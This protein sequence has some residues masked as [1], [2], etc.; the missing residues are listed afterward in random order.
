MNGQIGVQSIY[1]RGSTFWIK[2][3][4]P[5]AEAPQS[6]KTIVPYLHNLKALIVDDIKANCDIAEEHLL[7][8]GMRPQYTLSPAAV[9]NMLRDAKAT[10]DPFKLVILDYSMPN[11]NGYELAKAI[12]GNDQFADVSLIMLTSIGQLGDGKMFR[13]I[14]VNGYLVKPVRSS[15]LLETITSSL[16]H[17]AQ[18]DAEMVTRHVLN[19]EANSIE[20]KP[21]TQS[22]PKTSEDIQR[23]FSRARL[24]TDFDDGVVIKKTLS[25]DSADERKSSGNDT[26]E[27][28]MSQTDSQKLPLKIAIPDVDPPVSDDPGASSVTSA[29]IL[30][31]EDK[32]RKSVV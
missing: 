7:K 26:P 19:E 32:D 18:G 4:L 27:R 25:G 8:W 15:V 31:V 14:G 13:E 28:H 23:D 10:G 30:L 6:V 16:A 1:G 5:L 12:R 9:L 24:M 20:Q 29:K 17:L 11:I 2:L 22:V 3:T 21:K